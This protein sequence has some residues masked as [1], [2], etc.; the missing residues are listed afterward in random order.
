M[1]MEKKEK[2]LHP[3]LNS[4][5]KALY[6]IIYRHLTCRPGMVGMSC[7]LMSMLVLGPSLPSC[8]PDTPSHTMPV[9]LVRTSFRSIVLSLTWKNF[10]F[11]FL[12]ERGK[13]K[14]SKSVDYINF[15]HLHRSLVISTLNL[16][17]WNLIKRSRIY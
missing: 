13:L 8:L 2:E 9:E 7:S 15:L 12:E 1:Q 3:I 10:F 4:W 5:L 17:Q 16:I 6:A 11:F 14:H